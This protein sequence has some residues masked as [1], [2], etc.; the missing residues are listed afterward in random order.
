MLVTRGYDTSQLFRDDT[1][2]RIRRLELEIN[3]ITREMNSIIEE[4]NLPEDPIPIPF[5]GAEDEECE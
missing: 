3:E 1:I 5:P 4:G 2:V